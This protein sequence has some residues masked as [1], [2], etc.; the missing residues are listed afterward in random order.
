M[1]SKL[2]LHDVDLQDFLKTI[3]TCEG[4]VFLETDE[5]DCLNLKSKLCQ[6]VG[7]TNLIKGGMIAEAYIRCENPADETKLFRFNLYKEV[8][9]KQ[10]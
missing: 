2:A 4:D 8:P 10:D 6:L 1:R 7:L 9:E 5:G 3:D